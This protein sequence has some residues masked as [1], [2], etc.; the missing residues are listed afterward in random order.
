MVVTAVPSSAQRPVVYPESDGAPMAESWLQ[1]EVIHMLKTGFVRVMRGQPGV[2]VG[3]DNFWYPVEGD[4][5]TVVAPDVIVIVGMPRTPHVREMGSYRQ[6]EHGGHPALVVEVLSPSNTAAEMM[7]KLEFYDRHGA[8][9]Y[10]MFDPEAGTLQVWVR[11]GVHLARV[12][13]AERGHVSAATGVQVRTDG[14]DLVV[15]D[16]D[17]THRWG[18]LEAE[19]LAMEH[20]LERAADA[21]SAAA[22]ALEEVAR[23]RALLDRER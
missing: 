4:P 13:D 18:T 16:P 5:T 1:A 8:D 6:W 14:L 19:V 22:A 20:A 2:V 9:E 10:W 12:P 23:L 17:G 15:H 7:R 21:E 11:D 3:G